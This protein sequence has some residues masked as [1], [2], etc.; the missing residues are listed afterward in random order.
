MTIL[1]FQTTQQY[2]FSPKDFLEADL[3]GLQL[4]SSFFFFLMAYIEQYPH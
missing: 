2:L 3:Y 4:P 1:A